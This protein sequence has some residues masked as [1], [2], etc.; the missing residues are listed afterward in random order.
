LKRQVFWSRI[1]AASAAIALVVVGFFGW[2]LHRANTSLEQSTQEAKTNLITA[3][4]NLWSSLAA[5]AKAELGQRP[6]EA[7]KLALAAW[8]RDAAMGIPKRDVTLNVISRSLASLHERR[9]IATGAAFSVAF[10]PDGKSVLTSSSDKTARLWDAATGKVIRA[11]TGHED[12][13]QSVAFSPDGKSVLTG[14]E[15]KTARLWDAATG[16]VIRAFT[17]H[18]NLVWSV[19]FSPDGKSVLTG[20]WDKRNRDRQR[21]LQFRNCLG[22]NCHFS[23]PCSSGMS[24]I[25][26]GSE[27]CRHLRSAPEPK[28]I[29]CNA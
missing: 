4:Q 9:R 19:A 18:E 20:S 17:G 8:P 10:S 15:D 6:L 21:A 24:P 23:R 16:K 13:V 26:A 3:R 22:S 27:S 11:F 2:N 25:A 7:A 14:S 29:R 5:L 28:V 12:A 1:F